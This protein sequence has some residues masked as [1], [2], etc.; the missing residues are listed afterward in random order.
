VTDD[1]WEAIQNDIAQFPIVPTYHKL[2][3]RQSFSRYYLAYTD[4]FQKHFPFLHLPSLCLQR[5]YIELRLAIAAAGAQYC[6]EADKPEVLHLF[7]A[8]LAIAADRLRK[9]DAKVDSPQTP[10]SCDDSASRDRKIRARSCSMFSGKASKPA[11]PKDEEDLL[12]T[13]QT[14]F[15]LLV[16]ATGTD[17]RELWKEKATIQGML[18]NII[19]EGGLRTG[20]V[21]QTPESLGW[22]EYM[23]RESAKRTTYAAF[24]FSN[25]DAFM[26]ETAPVIPRSTLEFMALPI[27]AAEFEA[28]TA[29]KWQEVRAR[30][31]AARPLLFTDAFNRLFREERLPPQMSALGNYVL[32]HAVTYEI[33]I[34][35]HDRRYLGLTIHRYRARRPNR[36]EQTLEGLQTAWKSSPR[37]PIGPMHPDACPVTSSSLFAL[38][39][40]ASIQLHALTTSKVD[41]TSQAAPL[42]L[43]PSRDP[44]K[45]AAAMR[46]Y[47]FRLEFSEPMKLRKALM[48]AI[49][50]FSIPI[51]IGVNRAANEPMFLSMMEHAFPALEFALLLSKWCLELSH[52]DSKD[53]SRD[54][55]AILE[56]L[57]KLMRETRHPIKPGHYAFQTW[58][59]DPNQWAK[60]HSV[61][62]LRVW[63]DVYSGPQ[64]WGLSKLVASS[65]NGYAD[66][67][68]QT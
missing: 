10:A 39:H 57:N 34:R 32:I 6:F 33:H 9:K 24:C 14:L 68:Q 3:T 1:D 47:Q 53:I 16:I 48:H 43:L 36:L 41:R 8:A 30:S 52:R 38:L 35:R 46:D 56:E 58:A 44:Q 17:Y 64:I 60:H 27:S 61:E 62:V 51:G 20:S 21:L 4:G 37:D 29:A 55:T 19:Q 22:K 63:A 7:H 59:G 12:Q 11:S 49:Q 23:R 42:S 26:N 31:P 67:L 5:P 28:D 2:P 13:A 65:L 18:A 66:F 50:A 45:L 54:E 15:I 25:F 40:F